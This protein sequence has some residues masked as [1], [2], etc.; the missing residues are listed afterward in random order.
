MCL[1]RLILTENVSVLLE[2]GDRAGKQDA[3]ASA[4]MPAAIQLIKQC[5]G[6]SNLGARMLIS[7]SGLGD[8]GSCRG[9]IDRCLQG[10]CSDFECVGAVARG[11]EGR[12]ARCAGECPHARNVPADE[13]VFKGGRTWVHACW[14]SYRGLGDVEV[15]GEGRKGCV[16]LGSEVAPT[17]H[18]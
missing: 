7:Y 9:C 15:M 14:T 5:A 1:Q 8:E 2:G 13:A 10:V 12:D 4:R 18:P 17:S 11:V 3:L 6:P 16:Q